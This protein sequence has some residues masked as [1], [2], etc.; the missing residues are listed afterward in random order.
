MFAIVMNS[1]CILGMVLSGFFVGIA[2]AR[3]DAGI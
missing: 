1:A 2:F 3:H